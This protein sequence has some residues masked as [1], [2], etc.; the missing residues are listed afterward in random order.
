MDGIG[1]EISE[2]QS[3]KITSIEETKVIMQICIQSGKVS[4]EFSNQIIAE[5]FACGGWGVVEFGELKLLSSLYSGQLAACSRLPLS[6]SVHHNII[7]P[8]AKQ[9]SLTIHFF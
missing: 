6:V 8:R 3:A 5:Y 9:T 1:L 4:L 7:Q 2:R